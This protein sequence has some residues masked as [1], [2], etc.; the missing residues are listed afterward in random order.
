MYCV[1]TT[2]TFSEKDC[3][4]RC[5]TTDSAAPTSSEVCT[6]LSAVVPGMQ[7]T[8]V[9]VCK[10]SI[11]FCQQLHVTS[12]A[13]SAGMSLFHEGGIEQT[14]L[15]PSQPPAALASRTRAADVDRMHDEDVWPCRIPKTAAEPV[16]GALNSLWASLYTC[17]HC[18]A[19]VDKPSQ[20]IPKM[21]L[22][23][24]ST[25]SQCVPEV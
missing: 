7:K 19:R 6:A 18:E 2:G 12:I 14:P 10:G 23:C 21:C 4:M 17:K 25:K 20:R 15:W 5:F 9:T 22:S 11:A 16:L 13:V 24:I 1:I 3:I 8:T